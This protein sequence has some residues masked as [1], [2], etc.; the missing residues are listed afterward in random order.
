[1]DGGPSVY[2]RAEAFSSG[3]SPSSVLLPV[4]AILVAIVVLE[5]DFHA[6]PGSVA[7]GVTPSILIPLGAVPVPI[8]AL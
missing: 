2:P 1:M 3:E 5:A 4:T 8:S 6:A 7:I